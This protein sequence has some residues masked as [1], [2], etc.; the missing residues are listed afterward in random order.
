MLLP[1]IAS[2]YL[3]SERRL[4]HLPASPAGRTR[5]CLFTPMF[6]TTTL[7]ACVIP[8]Q[9]PDSDCEIPA[10]AWIDLARELRNTF[11][12]ELHVRVRSWPKSD[13][14][15][16]PHRTVEVLFQGAIDPQAPLPIIRFIEPRI[17]RIVE[18]YSTP[19]IPLAG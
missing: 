3:L 17:K 8:A 15:L 19:H 11:D 12:A 13:P 2:T 1:A 5:T 14:E 9:T 7:I 4:Q 18:Q 6:M 16:P 10:S